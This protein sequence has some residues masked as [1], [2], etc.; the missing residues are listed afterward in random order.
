MEECNDILL[1]GL[2]QQDTVSI[3][4]LEL[5][6]QRSDATRCEAS[7]G[8]SAISGCMYCRLG[9]TSKYLFEQVL[10]EAH[11][12]GFDC[13]VIYFPPDSCNEVESD[14]I[15]GSFDHAFAFVLRSSLCTA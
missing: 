14:C 1:S 9:E 5:H 6:F 13:L 15:V 11:F 4:S 10:E 8:R 2:T 12:G 3:V 7:T